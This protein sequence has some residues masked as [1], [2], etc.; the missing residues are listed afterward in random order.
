MLNHLVGNAATG[1]PIT[2]ASLH[3]AFPPSDA[4]ELAG[5]A[6]AY[7]RKALAFEADAGTETA[8]SVDVSNQ[9][10][11]D[12]PAGA[13]VGAAA[14]RAADGTIMADA[15]LTDEVYAAQGTYTLTDADLHLNN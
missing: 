11:F 12:I 2:Q 7:A 1:G 13:T 15:D 14:F 3:S 10:V 8:G 5:G 9:P 6:P 4:N